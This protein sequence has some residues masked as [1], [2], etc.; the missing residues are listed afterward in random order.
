MLRRSGEGSAR[1]WT[2]SRSRPTVA[3]GPGDPA[4]L[5]EPRMLQASGV[6]SPAPD[7]DDYVV[8][9]FHMPKSPREL[10]A[11]LLEWRRPVMW[12]VGVVLAWVI[13]NAVLSKGL[14][15]GVV[16]LGVIYG[17]LY[18]LIAIG[19]V[20]VYRGSRIINFAQAQ[21]G[22]IAAI[23]AIELVVNYHVNWFVAMLVGSAGSLFLGAVV[24]TIIIRRFR[25]SSRLIL[26]VATI[27]LAQLLNGFSQIIPLEFCNPAQNQS[28]ITAA[29]T[30]TFNTPLHTSFSVSPVIFSGNDIVAVGGAAIIVVLL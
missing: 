9:K 24:Q 3:D 27:G 21:F 13:L 7:L 29:N 8:P 25:R 17:S 19:I 30:Q 14:P 16:L 10:G 1:R 12:M 11:Q 4:V 5:G 20:L 23:V 22:V 6:G 26:T 18:A 2:F 15:L 28:C